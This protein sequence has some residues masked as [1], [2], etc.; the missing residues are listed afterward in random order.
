MPYL[1]PRVDIFKTEF[2]SQTLAE[3]FIETLGFCRDSV[4]IPL[5]GNI[6]INQWRIQDLSKGGGGAMSERSERLYI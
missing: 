4:G 3:E 2:L 1:T 5:F 6:I